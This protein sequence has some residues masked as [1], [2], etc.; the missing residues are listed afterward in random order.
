MNCVDVVTSMGL[1]VT[2]MVYYTASD[3]KNN[4]KPSTDAH[5]AQ[6][7]PKYYNYRRMH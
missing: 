4:C 7:L 5:I 1:A 2:A 6:T 3:P